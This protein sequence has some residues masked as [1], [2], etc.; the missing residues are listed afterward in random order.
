MSERHGEAVQASF[1]GQAAAFED[2]RLN[3]VYA[4]GV[5]WIFERLELKSHHLVLD[6]AGGTAHAGRSLA[7]TVAAVVVIDITPAMLE[8]GKVGADEGG[9]RNIV[10]QHGDAGQPPFLD[11]SFDIVVSRFSVHHFERPGLQV[12]EMVRCLRPGG[13]AVVADLVADED[14]EVA[15]RQNHLERLRDPSHAR[16]LTA[17]ELAELLER[18]EAAV[19]DVA[20]RQVDRPL[21]P[22]LAQTK[23]SEEVGREIS[24]ALRAEIA[25]DDVTGFRP[26]EREGELWFAQRFASV[27]ARKRT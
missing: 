19:V 20:S 23:A 27:T 18:N 15:Q 17:Q 3:R 22:W 12:A 9:L 25:G 11:A 24:D 7:P 21:A 8:A 16:L 1:S 2:E 13:Q 5:E 10:F 6:V 4:T 26:H 14:D